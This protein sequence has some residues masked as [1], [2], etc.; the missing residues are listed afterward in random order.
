MRTVTL[1]P[2]AYSWAREPRTIASRR[3]EG[4]EKRAERRRG[5]REEGGEKKREER[6]GSAPS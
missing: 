1:A 6:R 3:E 5:R 4:G 2:V